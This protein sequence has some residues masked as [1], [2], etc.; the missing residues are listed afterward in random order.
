MHT[1]LDEAFKITVILKGLDSL[2]EII[3]GIFFLLIRPATISQWGLDIAHHLFNNQTAISSY[4][5]NSTHSLAKSTLLGALYLL[6]HGVVKVVLVI[7]VLMNKL[8]AY[9]IFMA[10]IILFIGYQIYSL[11][12]HLSFG[13]SLLTV[14]DVLVVVLTWL[15]WQK[16]LRL[17]QANDPLA[18]K[19]P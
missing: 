14:F 17:R 10:V 16:Q 5:I 2:L 15:E 1:R 12:N 7:L 4:L 19:Q 6:I 8:W 18:T 9:P 13:M 11:V 3:G